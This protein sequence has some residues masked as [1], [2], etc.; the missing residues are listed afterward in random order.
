MIRPEYLLKIPYK[1][2]KIEIIDLEPGLKSLDKSFVA[3]LLNTSED[4]IQHEH[5][6]KFD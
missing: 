1:G 6:V 2:N 4:R 5:Q 3:K